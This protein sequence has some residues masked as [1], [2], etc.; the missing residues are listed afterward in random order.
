MTRA[1]RSAASSS[2]TPT[3][4]AAGI[5]SGSPARPVPTHAMPE[6]SNRWSTDPADGVEEPVVAHAQ[7]RQRLGQ[8]A[9]AVLG[10]RR[11]VALEVGQARRR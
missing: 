9:V 2:P 3:N 8:L 7:R 11:P 5:S 6:S 4:A 1:R 10:E